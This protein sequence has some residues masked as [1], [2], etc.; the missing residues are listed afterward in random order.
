MARAYSD[1]L[2]CKILQA[3][4]RGGVSLGELA[5]RFGVS[6]PYTKKIHQQQLRTG[7][8]ERVPQS[9]YGPVSRVTAAAEAELQAQVRATPDATLAELR[10]AL[11]HKQQIRLSRS[12]MWRVLVRMG[13]RLKKNRSTPK[14]N[15][16]KKAVSGGR[17]GGTR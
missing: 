17:R 1:D 5:E 3:Y 6:L 4:E 2:R 11:W 7:Q 13:L 12:Q 16:R 9:R 10:Q 14:S 8:M 15:T